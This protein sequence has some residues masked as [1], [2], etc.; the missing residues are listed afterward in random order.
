MRLSP[1][2][3]LAELTHSQTALRLG[4]DN[5]PSVEVIH[6]LQRLCL[7]LLQPIRDHFGPVQVASGY[8]CPELN[9]HIGGSSRSQHCQGE[10]AD[11][12]IATVKP[13][14]ICR[15]VVEAGLPFD[16]L[17]EEG[18]WTHISSADTPRGQVLTAH[19]EN[20]KATYSEGL[21][22]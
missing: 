1:A 15:F 10:A 18:T 20:G 14:D 3:T 16:Q 7:E 5:D 21:L 9:K 8:R 2:F 17:I 11:I 22:S 4:I 19:F 12:V 6:A 13:I